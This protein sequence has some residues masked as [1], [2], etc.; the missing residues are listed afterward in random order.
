MLANADATRIPLATGSVQMCM[1]SPP[2]WGLRKYADHNEA[3]IG[4]EASLDDYLARMLAVF[5]EVKRVLRDDGTVW[6]NLGDCFGSG[7]RKTDKR[8]SVARSDRDYP[9]E[10]RGRQGW[11]KQLIGLPWRVAFMLQADGWYLRSDIIWHKPNPMPESVTD[12]PTKSHEYLFLLAKSQRYYYDAEAVRE[13]HK[14]PNRGKGERESGNPHS[15]RL[16]DPAGKEQ[17]AF[18]VG[19]RQY[20]PNGRNRRDVW[21]IPTAPYKGSHFA[22]FP[23]KLVEP[24]VLAGTSAKGHCPK[25]GA[26]WEREVER[27]ALVG[28]DRGGNYAG[29]EVD[30][31]VYKNPGTPGMAY[32]KTTVGWRPACECGLDPVPAIVLDPFCGSGTVGQVCR[33]LGRR[34]VGLDISMTYLQDLAKARVYGQNGMAI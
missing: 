8:Q 20:N 24:C 14:E 13:P 19:V 2:Y 23:P 10:D 9:I 34:F 27:G 15:G 12:R 32:E 7:G 17:A 3:T 31:M 11:A 18:T 26:G 6:L 33:E 4:L 5:R 29:R 22:T 21:T 30:P 25:C 16:D 28:K 1:T